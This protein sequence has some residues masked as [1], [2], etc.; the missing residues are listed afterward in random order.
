MLELTRFE[1]L[2][3]R[4]KSDH[5]TDTSLAKVTTDLYLF[6]LVLLLTLGA[7]FG[8]VDDNT[9]HVIYS[10]VTSELCNVTCGVLQGS[11]FVT[12]LFNINM[13]PL[14]DI[15]HKYNISFQCYA[16]DIQLYCI[17]H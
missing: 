11:V 2:S 4:F 8:T 16:D 10:G 7:A 6:G 12:L 14:G 13:L 9:Q 17:C 5:S 3:A 1:L 15:I